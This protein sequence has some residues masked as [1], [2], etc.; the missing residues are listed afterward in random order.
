ML[1]PSLPSN[2]L[3]NL[4]PSLVSAFNTITVITDNL[5][6]TTSSD[7]SRPATN[8]LLSVVWMP[9]SRMELPSAQFRTCRRVPTSSYSMLV[10]AGRQWCIF[11]CGHMLCVIPPFSTTVCQCWRMGHQ[12]EFSYS[13]QFELGAIWSMCTLSHAQC[14]HYKNVLASGKLLPRWSPRT[15]LGLNLEPSPAHARNVYLVLNLLTGCVSPQYHC[16]FDD[17]FETTRHG[18]PDDSHTI[19]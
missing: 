14:L 9:I 11:P 19:C 8:D 7:H 12:K 3:R 1:R 15:R 6:T 18:Q 16:W 10:L 2:H 4:L 13:V 17:F 5:L